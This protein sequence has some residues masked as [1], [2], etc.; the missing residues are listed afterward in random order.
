MLIIPMFLLIFE[1]LLVNHIG[2]IRYPGTGTD[3]HGDY[4][5]YINMA[6]LHGEPYY[7]LNDPFIYRI[8][9][10][11][12]VRIMI[13]LGISLSKG[14]FLLMFLGMVFC[15][16]GIY[17]LARGANIKPISAMLVACAFTSLFWAAGFN[18][19][20]YYLVDPEVYAFIVWTL[21][22]AQ[23]RRFY[24]ASSLVTVGLLCKESIFLA[25][26]VAMVQLIVYYWRHSAASVD[27]GARLGFIGRIFQR[28]RSIPLYGWIQLGLLI[29]CPLI[30]DTV[31]H[32]SLHPLNHNDTLIVWQR[33]LGD[34]FGGGIT[35]GLWSS[36]LYSS[37]GTYG[38]LFTWAL[39]ALAFG[40][41]R[42]SGLSGWALLAGG[43]ALLYSY[44]VSFDNQRLAINYWPIVL[45]MAALGVQE[46]SERLRIHPAYLWVP[47]LI[48]QAIYEPV[49]NTFRTSSYDRSFSRMYGKYSGIAHYG[50]P[51][52]VGF[53][54]LIGLAALA[55]IIFFR[56]PRQPQDAK[57]KQRDIAE[58]ETQQLAANFSGR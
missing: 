46:L 23:Q 48:I 20:E 52:V 15:I 22:A 26:A 53:S 17:T 55:A 29:I 25:L 13:L 58:Q 8:L 35:K 31:L 14:F 6:M 38:V 39:V 30:V 51:L 43:F 36:F 37:Y 3:S 27:A 10:P 21:V 16:I 49:T 1:I 12:L 54:I 34:R 50:I 47:T 33:Y 5:R 32:L 24:L 42:R 57:G 40:A 4:Y 9:V 28:I 7:A 45:L 2:F 19:R 11:G 18:I 44:T 56:A 41:W